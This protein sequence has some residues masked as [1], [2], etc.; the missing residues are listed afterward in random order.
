MSVAS[1][2]M[3]SLV[4]CFEHLNPHI[5]TDE[6]PRRSTRERKAYVEMPLNVEVKEK[7]E[8]EI[9]PGKGTP[10]GDIPNVAQAIASLKGVDDILR[11]FYRTI[12]R[13]HQ[14]NK[15]TIKKHLRQ[16]SGSQPDEVCASI[17]ALLSN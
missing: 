5:S 15:L 17:I 2:L 8:L 11:K 1:K 12:F 4:L 6:A 10:L 7:A 14:P 9:V 3:T 16:Y 13:G